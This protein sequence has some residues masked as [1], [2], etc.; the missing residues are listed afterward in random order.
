MTSYVAYGLQTV[1]MT[2]RQKAELEMTEL[3]IRRMLS[4][5]AKMDRIRN[6]HDVRGTRH[7]GQFSNKVREERLRWLGMFRGGIY[8]VSN[9][10]EKVLG[11]ELPGKRK[12]GWSRKRIWRRLG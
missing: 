12:R 11:M 4:S 10:R 3:K 6:E 1:A 2:S 7:V 5:V 9:Y 8:G